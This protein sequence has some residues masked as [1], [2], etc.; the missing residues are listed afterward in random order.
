MFTSWF[1]F[2]S[3]IVWSVRTWG[4]RLEARNNPICKSW[5]IWDREFVELKLL[6]V[7]HS[8]IFRSVWRLQ[9]NFANLWSSIRLWYSYFNISPLRLYILPNTLIS[10]VKLKRSTIR[11]DE[12]AV[13]T[14]PASCPL[15]TTCSETPVLETSSWKSLT[16][17]RV[18]Q[19]GSYLLVFAGALNLRVK[20]YCLDNR[21]NLQ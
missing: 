21:V 8:G 11:Y 7:K 19:E 1:H 5:H 2:A 12:P 3:S 18:S 4:K 20:N 10:T 17:V 13:I 9:Y 6:G 15:K 16:T 14:T